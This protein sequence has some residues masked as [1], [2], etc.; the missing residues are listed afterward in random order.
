MAAVFLDPGHGGSDPGGTAENGRRESESN[1]WL[2]L[3]LAPMLVAAGHSVRLSREDDVAL[4]TYE[5]VKMAW[6]WGTD[7]L[8]S[9]QI[10][11]AGNP[12]PNGHHVIHSIK[13][14]P[15]ERGHKLG[16]LLVQGIADATGRP[17][18]ARY[19]GPVW[20]RRNL[21]LPWLDY[22][23]VIRYAIARGIEAPVI[24][25]RGFLSNPDDRGLLFDEEYLVMQA[26]GIVT[27]VER[28]GI[29]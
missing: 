12:G 5:R 15:G 1:L 26:G 20:T 21:I 8:L 14:Q 18:F 27:A 10:D 7:L 16:L 24:L 28:Y 29:S 25:E 11:S 2:A 4:S 3:I 9:L 19:G 6:E 23:A 13:D 17:P 22:Y